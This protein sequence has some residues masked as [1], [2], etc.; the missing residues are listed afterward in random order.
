VVAKFVKFQRPADFDAKM[1][2]VKQL[3]DEIEEQLSCIEIT[4]SEPDDIQLQLDQCMVSSNKRWPDDTQ[5]QP[6]QCNKPQ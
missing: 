3:L 4:S 2:K 5:F 1:P 6:D